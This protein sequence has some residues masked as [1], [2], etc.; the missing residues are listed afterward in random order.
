MAGEAAAIPRVVGRSAQG[1][2]STEGQLGGSHQARAEGRRERTPPDRGPQ[3]R[4]L[5]A[6]EGE[7]PAHRERGS[8]V[9]DAGGAPGEARAVEA[10][11]GDSPGALPPGARAPCSALA[12]WDGRAGRDRLA[13][14]RADPLR[15]GGQRGAVPG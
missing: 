7:A 14:H 12:R 6:A 5:L 10:R 2:R 8:N 4:L 1:A 9:P 15:E 13:C 3:E 11:E